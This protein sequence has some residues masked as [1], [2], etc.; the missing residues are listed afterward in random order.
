MSALH[1]GKSKLGVVYL[2]LLYLGG[3]GEFNYN[4]GSGI[5]DMDETH[6]FRGIT[7]V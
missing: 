4:L 2:K 6:P 5:K 1:R 3:E 7:L